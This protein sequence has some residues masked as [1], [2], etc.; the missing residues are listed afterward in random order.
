MDDESIK[1]IEKHKGDHMEGKY[2]VAGCAVLTIGGIAG[3]ALY[4]GINGAI[5][6][7]AVGSITII[8]GYAFGYIK[9]KKQET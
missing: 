6:S 2:F 1:S 4:K 5:T 7:L 9:G 3:M 8:V